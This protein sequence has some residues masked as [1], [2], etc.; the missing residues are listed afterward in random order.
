M[1]LRIPKQIWPGSKAGR[2][3]R[4]CLTRPTSNPC[5][6]RLS[7]AREKKGGVVIGVTPA[8]DSPAPSASHPRTLR[9]RISGTPPPRSSR[10]CRS[11]DPIREEHGIR[12]MRASRRPPQARVARDAT[13]DDHAPRPDLFR[14][15]SPAAAILRSR[16]LKRREQIQRSF[17]VTAQPFIDRWLEF[18]ISKARRAATSSAIS[19]ASNQ[20]STAVFS[21]LKLKSSVLPFILASVKRTA[22]GLPCGASISITGPPG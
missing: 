6:T 8:P 14:A 19:R 5:C 4:V 20:R 10:H 9:A 1:A 7:R 21:P 18:G 22:C 11:R 15:R 12:Q 16:L 17:G 3:E 2:G 13:R